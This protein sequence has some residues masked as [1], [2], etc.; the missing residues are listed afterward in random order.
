MQQT[1]GEFFMK[2]LKVIT[3]MSIIGMAVLAFIVF[4]ISYSINS[5]NAIERQTITGEEKSIRA[6]YDYSI[7]SE[8]EMVI[9]LLDS[10]NAD[11]QAGIYTKEEGMKLAAGKI[12]DLRYG[13]DGY[14]WVDQS[15]GVNVVLLGNEI[16][17]TNRMGTKDATG[18]EMVK[19]FI[20]TSVKEGSYFCDYQYPKEGE[21]EPKPKRAYTQYYEPFGWVVGTG[22][23]IDNIDEQIAESKKKADEYTS[24]EIRLFL[25]ICVAFAIAIILFLAY[26]IF[27]ITK[28]LKAVGVGMKNMAEGD[29]SIQANP[30]LLKRKDDFGILLN[31]AE[32]MRTDIGALVNDVK[33]ETGLITESVDGIRNSMYQLNNEIDDVSSTTIQLSASMEETSAASGDINEMTREIESA[34]RNVAERAQEGAEHAQDIYKKA[35]SAKSSTNE[36]KLSLTKQKDSIKDNLNDALEKVKVVSEIS[37]LAESIMEI[38]TQTNL[39]SLNA[40]IEAARA[41]EAGK[42]FAVVAD[43]IRKLA[44]ASQE[45]TENI[46]K[47]TEQVSESVKSLARDSEA[48]LSFIDEQVMDSI[49]LFESISNDY[50]ED[51]KETDLLVADFSA[52][53]EELLASIS[54]IT[55]S[56]EG[57]SQAAS[58][59]AVGTA[60]I[61]DRITAIVGTSDS[62]NT[63][64]QDSNQIVDKLNEATNKFQL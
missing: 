32:R 18:Y 17:G 20:T 36:T 62:V 22:N 41:G 25:A 19:D 24:R 12:R 58:E 63:S 40:S 29:F 33:K 13:E 39:L 5:M 4:S 28:P 60:N 52:I 26:M 42:G 9:T 57:I 11:I 15:D 3:K 54:N 50:N 47:V 23:Y 45:S 51:A 59:S 35:A 31:I 49:Q 64:L 34:A 27:N 8:V 37:T 38:T 43:E 1:K 55:D 7:K 2:N 21:T 46:K 61:A 6:D 10:Y 14:F 30:A 44:E 53:S 56:I 48:L 16:E